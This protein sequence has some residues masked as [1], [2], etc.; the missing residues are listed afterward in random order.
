MKKAVL[1]IASLLTLSIVLPLTSAAVTYSQTDYIVDS[2]GGFTWTLEFDKEIK[3]ITVLAPENINPPDELNSGNFFDS[4]KGVN[5]TFNL[6]KNIHSGSHIVG[7]KIKLKSEEGYL[8]PQTYFT[9]VAVDMPSNSTVEGRINDTEDYLTSLFNSVDTRTTGLEEKYENLSSD[10]EELE[11]KT[12]NLRSQLQDSQDRIDRLESEL[13][14]LNSTESPGKITSYITA[15]GT[16]ILGVLILIGIGAYVVYRRYLEGEE[17][18]EVE[19]EEA[20]QDFA[21]R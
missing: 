5:I 2:G 6:N 11:N 20:P 18:E 1:F 7:V 17:E 8:P 21:P 14:S 10:Y 19:V 3:K 9:T 15:N 4:R 16:E 13:E 12:H